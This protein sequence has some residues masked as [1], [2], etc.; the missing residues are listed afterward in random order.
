MSYFIFCLQRLWYDASRFKS[1]QRFSTSELIDNKLAK[2]MDGT[3]ILN[4]NNKERN[5]ASAITLHTWMHWKILRSSD[6]FWKRQ[7]TKKV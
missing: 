7:E 5:H 2:K 3:K 6:K 4:V 1:E